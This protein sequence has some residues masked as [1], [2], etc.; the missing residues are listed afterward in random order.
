VQAWFVG[1]HDPTFVR[2]RRDELES[3]W[4]LLQRVEDAFDP[5]PGSPKYS[6]IVAEFLDADRLY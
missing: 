5:N 4:Q 3:Y 1:N 6:R 2:S